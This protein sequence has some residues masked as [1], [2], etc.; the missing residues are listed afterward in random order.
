MIQ[1]P[2]RDACYLT[3]IGVAEDLAG[4]GIGCQLIDHLL[5]LGRLEGHHRAALDVSAANP[6]AQALYERL[7][8]RVMLERPSGVPGIA[9]HRFMVRPLD[10]R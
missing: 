10:A 2:P 9:A 6:R 3:H 8:F 1:P 7:G 4:Q 5:H